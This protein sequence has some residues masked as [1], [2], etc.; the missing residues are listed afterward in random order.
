MSR[1]RYYPEEA[2]ICL[3]SGK[4]ARLIRQACEMNLAEMAKKTKCSVVAISAF[5]HGKAFLHVES[6][7]RMAALMP[8]DMADDF[9]TIYFNEAKDYSRLLRGVR[10]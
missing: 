3:N 2:V 7:C 4:M 9:W 8:K 1:L 5:E 6:A 10:D